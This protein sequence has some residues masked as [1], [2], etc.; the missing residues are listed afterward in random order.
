GSGIVSWSG[1]M[2]GIY[3]EMGIPIREVFTVDNGLPWQA[4]MMRPELWLH[5]EWAV[6]E[7]GDPVQSAVNRLARLGIDQNRGP[8][9]R[10]EQSIIVKNAPAIEIYRRT[11]GACP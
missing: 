3:R 1:T 7:G 9:Y 4:A 8:C 10:L 6:A 5:Q 2:I 11:G